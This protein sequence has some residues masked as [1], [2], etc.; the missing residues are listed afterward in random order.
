MIDISHYHIRFIPLLL[1][2]SLPVLLIW[3]IFG[4]IHGI[5][6][7]PIASPE[8]QSVVLATNNPFPS[9]SQI[10]WKREPLITL[11]FDDAWETQYSRAFPI[12]REKAIQGVLAVTTRA[13]GTTGYMNWDDVKRLASDGWEITAHTRTHRCDPQAMSDA[14]ILNEVFGSKQDLAAMGIFTDHFVT[15]C[16][17]GDTRIDTIAEKYFFSLRT[18]EIGYNP[19]PKPDWYS[20]K[21]Q[22]ITPKVTVQQISEWIA[23][24]K[25]NNSWL[26]LMFHQIDNSGAEYSATEE[27]L[28]QTVEKV[29]SE[30]IK[31][32]TPSQVYTLK[33]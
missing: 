7:S 12:L 15:P 10:E 9:P 1:W 11:W 6:Q 33:I 2:F 13:I 21:V 25:K 24:A 19:L 23:E 26:I 29:T 16:G 4:Y 8:T 30:K 28:R 5:L 22:H 3:S 31:T 32:V 27:L 20:L 17:A 14:D 18:S